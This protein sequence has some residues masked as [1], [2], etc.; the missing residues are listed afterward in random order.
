MKA[1]THMPKSHLLKYVFK[2]LNT[3][4]SAFQNHDLTLDLFQ[5]KL[6]QG[7]EECFTQT[8]VYFYRE[9]FFIKLEEQHRTKYRNDSQLDNMRVS[10]QGSAQK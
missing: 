1:L 6:I 2:K 5:T 8:P 3:C 4:L 9:G 10:F 7:K